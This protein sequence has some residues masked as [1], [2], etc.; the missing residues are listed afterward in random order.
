MADTTPRKR[1]SVIAYANISNLT[2]KL[3]HKSL[4][5]STDRATVCRFIKQFT[6]T[7]SVT[8]QRKGKCGRKRFPFPR[9]DALI[10][11]E[12]KRIFSDLFCF[13]SKLK[14]QI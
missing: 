2:K 13:P 9:D 4:G 8:T 3:L 6:A 12:S 7:G 11:R 1:A 10:L 14:H 5:M